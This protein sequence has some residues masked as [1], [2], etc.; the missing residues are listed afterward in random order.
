MEKTRDEAK[1]AKLVLQNE[2]KDVLQAE[3]TAERTKYAKYGQELRVA[4]RQRLKAAGGV[5]KKVATRR[6]EGI[7][8]SRNVVE[9]GA[10]TMMTGHLT[11][12]G[13][14]LRTR[15]EKNVLVRRRS[16]QQANSLM[17][18]ISSLMMTNTEE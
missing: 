7:E 3:Y 1:K 17:R 9:D 10:R 4:V 11:E 5:A 14:K 15:Y 6:K 8:L 2:L 18:G 13:T 16:A 12:L